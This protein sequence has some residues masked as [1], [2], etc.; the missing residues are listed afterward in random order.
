MLL[1]VALTETSNKTGQK[2]QVGLDTAGVDLGQGVVSREQWRFRSLLQPCGFSLRFWCWAGASFQPHK[3][4]ALQKRIYIRAVTRGSR[5][6]PKQVAGCAGMQKSLATTESNFVP[7]LNTAV[8]YEVCTYLVVFV[9]EQYC[10]CNER[11]QT[12]LEDKRQA[13]LLAFTT[14]C[15][16]RSAWSEC[17][18]VSSR[19]ALV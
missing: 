19:R 4:N 2:G 11:L 10:C 3:T 7:F 13:L 8:V 1:P 6:R 9:R 15:C 18:W 16:V 5:E 12:A 17:G 14:A